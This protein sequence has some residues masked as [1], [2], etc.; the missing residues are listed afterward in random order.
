MC[1]R[2]TSPRQAIYRLSGRRWAEIG[3]WARMARSACPGRRC[4]STNADKQWPG[5]PP[6]A[7]VAVT[8]RVSPA[9]GR[10]AAGRPGAPSDSEGKDGAP[11]PRSDS[12]SRA[13]PPLR[14]ARRA[15]P[16]IRCPAAAVGRQAGSAPNRRR[17]DRP[18]PARSATDV[19]AATAG[20]RG[21][22]GLPSR[23]PT[24]SAPS[25]TG[26]GRGFGRWPRHALVSRPSGRHGH[27]QTAARHC[28]HG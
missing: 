21:V 15:A 7:P 1:Y 2:T 3:R 22:C 6:S 27:G 14:I 8:V 13:D 20:Q 18:E 25:C 24:G 26:P 28:V 19:P 5:H 23:R 11:P 12:D 16:H 10:L 9:L 17:R 4:L